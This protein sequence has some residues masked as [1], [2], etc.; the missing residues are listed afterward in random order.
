M[1]ER[2]IQILLAGALAPL[3]VI[4]TASAQVRSSASYSTA[5]EALDSGGKIVSSSSY[6][7]AESSLGMVVGEG[8]SPA[9]VYVA[10]HGYVQFLWSGVHPIS[11]DDLELQVNE[12]GSSSF[13]IQ[14]IASDADGNADW[15]V[16]VTNAH[17]GS[18]STHE[19]GSVSYTPNPGF[20][21]TD[22]FT[23][24][25]TDSSGYSIRSTIT[26]TVLNAMADQAT[27]SDRWVFYNNSSFDGDAGASVNDDNAIAS[28]KSAL[29]PGGTATFA[30]LTSYSKGLNGIMI[31]ISNLAGNPILSDFGFRMGNDNN[32]ASWRAAPDPMS[33]IAIDD[34]GEGISRITLIWNDN[35]LDETVDANEAIAGAW[36]EVTVKANANTGLSSDDVFYF[37]NAIGETGNE[38]SNARV[39]TADILLIRNNPKTFLSPAPITDPYDLNRDTKVNTQDRLLA[40]NHKTTFLDELKLIDL[41]G[42]ATPMAFEPAEPSGLRRLGGAW[43]MALG[44]IN[45][46]SV[47]TFQGPPGA[48]YEVHVST[49]IDGD[50]QLLD[51]TI[52][53]IAP[54]HHQ[55]KHE[56]FAG[57]RLF[58]RIVPVSYEE[59]DAFPNL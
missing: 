49:D 26:V 21:G 55:I 44:M 42:G 2:P 25:L 46:Q 47:V 20:T 15:T 11:A 28:D 17:A 34:L 24:F 30:N 18:V 51:G 23:C 53:E 22:S 56:P 5:A 48:G 35:N 50:W 19:D 16:Y 40:R 54:G 1:Q 7:L 57:D 8:T 4:A 36:L 10:R 13:L 43:G 38:T 27:I 33:P 39:N 29:L 41:S 45:G 3:F 12:G 9:T 52:I 14:D 6:R 32:P 58:Y 37:G 31:D 59:D